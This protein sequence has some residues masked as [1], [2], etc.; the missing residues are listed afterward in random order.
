MYSEMVEFLGE[1][2]Q[3]MW[4]SSQSQLQSPTKIDLQSV[5]PDGSPPKLGPNHSLFM[6]SIGNSP[7]RRRLQINS[8]AELNSQ[9]GE[10]DMNAGGRSSTR[11][12]ESLHQRIDSLTNTNLQ[13][14]I[15]SNSLLEKLEN[16]QQRELK[17]LESTSS[18]KHENENLGSMLNRKTRKLKDV[19]EELYQ[20]KLE[21][22]AVLEER[23]KLEAEHK[24]TDEKARTLESK[25]EMGCAQY[26]AIVDSLTHYK[27]HYKV[28]INELREELET[29]RSE[30]TQHFDKVCRDSKTLDLKLQDFDYKYENLQQAEDV[31]LQFFNDQCGDILKQFN[32]HSWVDLYRESKKMV[33]AYAERMEL[34]LPKSFTKLIEDPLLVDV[35]SASFQIPGARSTSDNACSHP[36]KVPKLRNKSHGSS[37]NNSHTKRSSFY[38]GNKQIHNSPLPGTLPGVR[39]S[40]SRRV[41]SST[42]D[43]SNSSAE[44]SPIITSSASRNASSPSPRMVQTPSF[45]KKNDA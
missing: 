12:I 11:A 38:G 43:I 4:K 2:S 5:S 32:L 24:F 42:S 1:S 18:L 45:R 30:Q 25:M 14:T 35:E 19:E 27:T 29:L 7:T 20:I 17:L 6:A 31:R 21:H 33:I 15:Q 34:D 3:G 39:R 10:T 44:S 36:L 40:S 9:A 22:N 28:Q 23:V 26:D 8:T 16:A 41:K 13:L 37:G